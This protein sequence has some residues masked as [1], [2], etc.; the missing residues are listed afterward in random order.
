LLK[1]RVARLER[2][3]ERE[4]NKCMPLL[5][6]SNP[7]NVSKTPIYSQERAHFTKKPRGHIGE[8]VGEECMRMRRGVRGV[9]THAHEGIN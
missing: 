6:I 7:N 8:G 5:Q 9:E 2:M 4:K 3:R 1:E